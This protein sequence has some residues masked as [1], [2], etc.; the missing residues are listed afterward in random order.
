MD[1]HEAERALGIIRQVIQH[2]RDDLTD[3]NWGLIWIVHAF[4]N[5][6]GAAC[7]TFV[8]ERQLPAIWYLLPL[9][10]LAAVNLLIVRL[11]VVRDKGVR[12]FVEWQLHGI[13][14]TFIAFTVAVVPV[15][16]LAD[17]KPT[18]FGPLFAMGSGFGFAMNGV[19]FNRKFFYS[20]ALFMAAMLAAAAWPAVQWWIIGACWWVALIVPG[21]SFHREKMRRRKDVDSTRIL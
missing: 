1:R 3:R 12:S 11:L 15:L 10:I 13:W 6:V 5:F 21:V 16:H 17:A 7:G 14:V 9:S 20:A 2:T 19:I 4:T 8:D 18:L